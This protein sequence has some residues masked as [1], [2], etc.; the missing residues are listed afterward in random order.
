MFNQEPPSGVYNGIMPCDINQQTNAAFL[1]P[2]QLSKISS[3]RNGGNSSSRVK[4]TDNP[5]CQHA[6][7]ARFDAVFGRSI[8][9]ATGDRVARIA[10]NSAWS[11]GCNTALVLW[12]TPLP[13]TWPVAG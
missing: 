5:S 2:L 7:A 9:G 3:I 8:R 4:R 12:V 11:Q 10:A 13:L 6:H 1:W